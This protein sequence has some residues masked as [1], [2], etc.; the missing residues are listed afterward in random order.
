MSEKIYTVDE[1]AE[2]LKVTRKTV[3]DLM[4][5]GKLAYVSIG[6][7]NRRIR[8]SHLDAFLRVGVGK[9]DLEYT[10]EDA[11]SPGL[12]PVLVPG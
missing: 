9:D 10:E 6:K 4:R 3:Y 11:R 7:R 5:A 8:Q 12:A 2:Y 1:V